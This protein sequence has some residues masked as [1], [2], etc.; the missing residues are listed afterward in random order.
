MTI[1]IEHLAEINLINFHLPQALTAVQNFVAGNRID[2]P[3]NA[4]ARQLLEIEGVERCLIADTLVGIKYGDMAKIDEATA[5]VLA[6]ID[7]YMALKP[8]LIVGE[9]ALSLSSQIE[10]LA[11]SFI[12]PTLLRDNGNIRIISVTEGVVQIQFTGHCAGCPYAQ[13][14]LNNVIAAVLKKYLPQI[15]NVL[16][17]ES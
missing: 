15:Q 17:E 13:N 2:L 5:L 3:Q 11:D 4:L 16:M 14:T 10:T 12:R 7:D 1:K 6:E 8:S 9:S